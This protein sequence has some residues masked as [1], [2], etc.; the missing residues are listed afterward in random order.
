MLACPLW[1]ARRHRGESPRWP[2][3]RAVFA[4]TKWVPLFAPAIFVSMI[5]VGV[6]VD[7][8]RGPAATP[9]EGWAP[10]ARMFSPAELVGFVILALTF[11]PVAEEMCFRGLLYNKLRQSLAPPVALVLQAAAFGLIHQ[12]LGVGLAFAA[13]AG[14]LLLGVFYEWRKS[15]PAAAVLHA[16]VN[17]LGVMLLLYAAAV[18]PRR[19]WACTVIRVARAAS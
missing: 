16:S 19:D 10:V 9:S 18:A 12:P 13:G 17:V 14:G 7:S 1:I 5:A 4:Q 2:R 6:A 11:A 3:L 15:L 8:L